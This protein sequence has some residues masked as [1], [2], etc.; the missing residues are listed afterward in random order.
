MRRFS[1]ESQMPSHEIRKGFDLA[2]RCHDAYPSYRSSHLC[3]FAWHCED[4]IGLSD[5][6]KIIDAWSVMAT[7]NSSQLRAGSKSSPRTMSS[8]RGT[9]ESNNNLSPQTP[10][11]TPVVN[12]RSLRTHWRSRGRVSGPKR[13]AARLGVPPS[14][15]EHRIKKLRIR[16]SHFKLS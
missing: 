3:Q 5:G 15:L 4:Q 2:R 6:S 9:S 7:R 11:R 1:S 10:M 14:T 13:V 12:G 8:S 16:K